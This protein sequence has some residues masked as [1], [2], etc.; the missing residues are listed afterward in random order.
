M[1]YVIIAQLPQSIDVSAPT[2]LM[3]IEQDTTRNITPYTFLTQAIPQL[4][5]VTSLEANNFTTI[6][7]NGA[8]RNITVFNYLTQGIPKLAGVAD[9]GRGDLV[10]I[11]RSGLEKNITVLNFLQKAIPQLDTDPDKANKVDLITLSHNNLAK[12][13]T[14]LDF[15]TESIPQL[16]IDPAKANKLDLITLSHNNEALNKTVLDFLTEAIPQLNIDP[17]KANKA[18]LITLSHNNEALNKTVLDFLTQSIPQLNID[19]A[20]ANKADLI[21]LSHNNEALNKTVL[22]FLTQ[23]IPQLD[24]TTTVNKTDLVPLSQNDST[25]NSTVLNFLSKGI[26]ELDLTSQATNAANDL[27]PL[28]QGALTNNKSVLDILQEAIPQLNTATPIL[29]TDLVPLGQ[30]GGFGTTFLEKNTTV[31][32][33]NTYVHTH[34]P[35]IGQTFYV[36]KSGVDADDFDERGKNVQLPYLT[37]KYAA[38][39]VAD[40]LLTNPNTQYTIM[41]ASGDYYENNPIY[42]PPKTSLIGDN[43]R[44]TSIYANNRNLDIIWVNS[45]CYIWGFTFR[46]HLEPSAAIAYPLNSAN[47]TL[48]QNAYNAA[49][50][51]YNSA[52]IPNS[53]PVIYVSPYTQ[54]CTSYATS[55]TMSS[56]NSYYDDGT[57]ND[58]GCG[59]RVD[60]SLVDGVIRSMVLDSFTQV[61]QG[62]KGIH[63]LN[64]GYAQL[65]SIFTISTTE[66]V[67]CEGGGTCS[68]STSNSTFGLSGLVARG[69]SVAPI[70][71]ATLIQSYKGENFFIIGNVGSMSLPNGQTLATSPYAG[72]CYTIGDNTFGVTQNLLN[73]VDPRTLKNFFINSTPL[74]TSSNVSRDGIAYKLFLDQNLSVSLSN[75]NGSII[76]F[77][78]R[79][80]I[81]TGSHTFEYIGTGTRMYSA[82]PSRGGIANNANEAVFDGLYDANAPG[83]V[84][85]TST[86]ELGN[87]SVGPQFTIVQSTGTIV[88]DTFNRSILT[89]VTPLN[90]ALE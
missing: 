27:L 42:L 62:G 80:Q 7:Q 5:I 29:S 33:V 23:S 83:I 19:P 79:S 65:V 74:L 11:A 8:T 45:A 51:N 84:Y 31:D 49:Y 12:N 48:N 85:Y 71:S 39:K 41:V 68:I 37:I 6:S 69:C 77:Y 76:R 81:A 25:Y 88:G 14:V 30:N 9:V 40:A 50:A 47:Q 73:P 46:N 90:I 54:G 67:L 22:E 34:A 87:Y 89:L 75:Y 10:P 55:S 15:L 3:I 24:P 59:M 61:N 72:L 32:K 63:V 78:L 60:G 17:A 16:N 18:D 1:A 2:D 64:H 20:N 4:T 57:V 38:K 43:L 44:R 53:R 82:I 21:T 26:A 56:P 70:L 28:T 52:S 35:K 66:G 58:A 36:G 13:K 86:N